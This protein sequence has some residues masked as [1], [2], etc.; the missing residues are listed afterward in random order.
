MRK[1]E[2]EKRRK[3][4]GGSGGVGVGLG[5]GDTKAVE[6]SPAFPLLP[7]PPPGGNSPFRRSS[8]H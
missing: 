5:G 4:V 1:G 7:A 2:K 6:P 8:G 3:E